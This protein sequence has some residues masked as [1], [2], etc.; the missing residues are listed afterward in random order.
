LT[1]IPEHDHPQ[2]IADVAHMF[3]R[4]AAH[5]TFAGFEP[6]VTA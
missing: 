3:E 1:S 4:H 6:V 2:R 5:V